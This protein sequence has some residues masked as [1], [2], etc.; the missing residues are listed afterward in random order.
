MEEGRK[1]DPSSSSSFN[2]FTSIDMSLSQSVGQMLGI[3]TKLEQMVESIT[4]VSRQREGDIGASETASGAQRAIIQS[5]N[6]TR[7]LFFYHDLVKQQVLQELLELAK[8]AFIEGGQIEHVV[9]QDTVETIKI[10]GDKL[11]STDLGVYV[12][13]SFEEA[14]QIQ[15]LEQLLNVALQTDKA[16]LSDMVAVLGEKS[17]SKIKDTIVSGERD[18]L[19]RD[20]EAS[21]AQQEQ[22][23]AQLQAENDRQEKVLD[24]DIYKANLASETDKE[25]ARIKAETE[26]AKLDVQL[27]KVDIDS[28]KLELEN[29]RAKSEISLKEKELA[30]KQSDSSNTGVNN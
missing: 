2:Q 7:P 3:L 30:I 20:A 16:N 14:E 11:N 15:K 18:K 6:N 23:N 5:T 26:L 12:P 1:G 4:G 13:S 21:K 25:I 24:L 29:D 19:R 8:V 17:I 27:S 9:D 10:D 22:F 28:A